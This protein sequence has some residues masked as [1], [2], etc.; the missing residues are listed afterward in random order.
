[1]LKRR[2]IPVQLLVGGRLVKTV[3][4]GAYRDVGDPVASSKVYNAQNADELVFLNI[5]REDRSVE[6]MLRLLERVSEEV[7]MPLALGGGIGSVDDA[8]RLIRAGADKVV[9]NSAA[10]RDPGL[11]R[12]IADRFGAQA[13][14]V[15]IDV[16][17]EGADGGC[18]LYS[19]CGR[20]RE[21]VGLDEHVERVVEHGAGEILVNS[22]DRDGTMEGYD[23]ELVRRVVERSPAPVIG[24]GGAGHYNH[25]K[26]GFLEAGASALAC[27]SLFNF[28]D[29]NPIR[30]KAFL[31]NYG[32]PF[33]VV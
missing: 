5:D 4:F 26:A 2:I 6:P 22:I 12:A 14:V 19:D 32:I 10:Y 18:V 9:V 21:A 8:S 33:K 17:R 23:L 16:R 24:C 11:L 27:G 30:A 15:G 31:T 29:N 28:G 1:M 7:F 20:R 25:L 13:V 3:R